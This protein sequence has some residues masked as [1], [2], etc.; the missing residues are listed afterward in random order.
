MRMEERVTVQGPVKEQ[1]P[2][3]MSHRGCSC[4]P[5]GACPRGSETSNPGVA[6]HKSNR[7]I[8]PR[9]PPQA[10]PFRRTMSGRQANG[11]EGASGTLT[12]VSQAPKRFTRRGISVAHGLCVVLFVV[13]PPGCRHLLGGVRPSFP[14]FATKPGCQLQSGVGGGEGMNVCATDEFS[15][16][17][18]Y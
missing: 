3:G 11:V 18:V 9:V 14:R 4:H 10:P 16:R 6:S 5:R 1:Q 8:P 7:C 2:D 13:F 15:L 12:L 17:G